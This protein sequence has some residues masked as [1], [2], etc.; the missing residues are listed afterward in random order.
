[1]THFGLWSHGNLQVKYGNAFVLIMLLFILLLLS[2]DLSLVLIGSITSFVFF[3][4]SLYGKSFLR[5]HGIVACFP[6]INRQTVAV[7]NR[8]LISD[9]FFL[10]Y[11]NLSTGCEF[12]KCV[13]HGMAIIFIKFKFWF[14]LLCSLRTGIEY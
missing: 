8:L 11:L 1:M 7:S 3:F 13:L 14:M 4:I 10:A 2:F 12:E 6:Y 9:P 5:A